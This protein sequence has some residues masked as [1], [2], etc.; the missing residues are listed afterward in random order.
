MKKVVLVAVDVRNT[1]NNKLLLFVLTKASI[2]SISKQI[3]QKLEWYRQILQ[4]GNTGY[5]IFDLMST[6]VTICVG[7]C[8]GATAFDCIIA[9]GF[10]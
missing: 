6:N 5:T 2:L 9:F 1:M 8:P 4:G 3:C 7:T 10:T